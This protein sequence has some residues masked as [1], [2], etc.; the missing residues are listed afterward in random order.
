M[1]NLVEETPFD[2][3]MGRTQF[4]AQFVNKE[5]ILNRIAL[6]I[7]CGFGWFEHFALR[8]GVKEIMGI[9]HEEEN[10]KT[11]KKYLNDSRTRFKVGSATSIPS[12]DQAFETVVSWDVI[13]HIPLKNELNMF[14]EVKRVL[15][16]GG[17]FYLSTPFDDFWSKTL[18]PA[19]WLI[20]HRHYSIKAL[21]AF[22]EQTGFHVENTRIEGG[23]WELIHMLNLYFA[24]WVF[25]R[26][27]FFQYFFS[28]KINAE[29]SRKK[30]FVTIFLK[31]VKKTD[32]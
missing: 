17:V 4:I 21:E 24:K 28:H 29:Y 9:E 14:R 15:K 6:N 8:N 25:H 7:G 13:E 22:A 20:G 23:W 30:G 31:L 11:A 1:K 5:D 26:R 32:K 3:L 19:W 16:P 10:L 18:D 12:P 2:P 27:P